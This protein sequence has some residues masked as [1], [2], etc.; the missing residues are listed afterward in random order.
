[1]S[2]I[3]TTREILEDRNVRIRELEAVLRPLAEASAAGD[4][5]MT[6]CQF[7][8][9]MGGIGNFPDVEHLDHDDDCAIVAARRVLGYSAFRSRATTEE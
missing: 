4:D 7:C 8:G 3:I 2:D 1:M 6:Y 9:A 5:C